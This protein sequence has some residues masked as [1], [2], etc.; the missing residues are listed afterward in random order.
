MKRLAVYVLGLLLVTVSAGAS[1]DIRSRAVEDG[2]GYRSNLLDPANPYGTDAKHLLSNLLRRYSL[3]PD[4]FWP[5]GMSNYEYA[6]RVRELATSKKVMEQI[7]KPLESY[8]YAY[9]ICETNEY[10]AALE[11]MANL[12]AELG[13]GEA[14]DNLILARHGLLVMCDRTDELR[15]SFANWLEKIE[16]VLLPKNAFV[17]WLRYLQ[18]AFY[19]YMEDTEVA[20][21]FFRKAGHSKTTPPGWVTDAAQY[22]LVRIAKFQFE[23]KK[24]DVIEFRKSIDDHQD[25]NPFSRYNLEV[26]NLR[27]MAAASKEE[28][29]ALLAEHF[30][31]FFKPSPND[32]NERYR[33]DLFVEV[34]NAKGI[35]AANVSPLLSTFQLMLK[36]A[37]ET[38]GA[39]VANYAWA[40]NISR[41]DSSIDLF[42]GL[43]AY[44]KLLKHFSRKEYQAVTST[45]ITRSKFQVLVSDAKILVARAHYALGNYDA[46]I[47]VWEEISNEI[48][49][50]NA[51]TEIANAYVKKNEFA[52]FARYR[53][54]R[55][56]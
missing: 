54:D 8:R 14:T 1:T 38:R 26:E 28:Y 7:D 31:R 16:E 11:F 9:G 19:F 29:A 25:A 2:I 34:M 32:K 4:Q 18:G 46:S 44:R 24:I 10:P 36:V 17:P 30:A 40:P 23:N 21:T 39:D 13:K 37:S 52:Q 51:L 48:A 43:S 27:R 55:F 15:I 41:S 12:V 49:T 20:E 50:F 53:S 45:H 33:H 35:V 3:L 5:K 56:S 6:L 47:R 22:M 42:P